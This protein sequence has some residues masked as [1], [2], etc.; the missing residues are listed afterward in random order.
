ML[1]VLG[2]I[3]ALSLVSA[4]PA[5]AQDNGTSNKSNAKAKVRTVTGCLSNG[6]SNDEYL[7]TAKDGSTWEVRSDKVPLSDH[8]GHMVSVTG[9]VSNATAH[10]LKEDAK[11]AAKDTG[12][13]KNETEHGHMEI[14]SLKMVS[15]SC[16][17]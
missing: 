3:F 7:L 12:V 13:K 8:L 14:T 5:M 17:E 2:I 4:A 16:K 9:V 6:E 10:N 1:R 11:E 15:K